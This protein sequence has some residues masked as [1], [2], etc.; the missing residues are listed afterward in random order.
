MA[1]EL[2]LTETIIQDKI[3]FIRGHKVML[4]FDL[5]EMYEVET[6]VLKQAV[7]RNID[8]FPDDFMLELTT[9][10]FQNLRSQIV[11]SSWG[12]LRYLPYAF[13][14]HGVLMLSIIL[15]SEQA[16]K[17]NIQIMRVYT[18]MKELLMTNKDI[19]LKLEQL[20]RTS[21]L[22]SEQIQGIFDLVKKLIEEPKDE[23]RTERIGFRKEW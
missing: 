4:D 6:K 23:E 3:Y 14:E 11:T 1:K 17:V 9:M 16:I 5:A 19:L 15:R 2:Q 18:K 12:G 10:E 7:K 20:E 8:R 21:G 13:T 22:H